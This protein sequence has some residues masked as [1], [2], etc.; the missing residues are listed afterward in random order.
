V[1]RAARS[2]AARIN[3][4]RVL[5]RSGAGSFICKACGTHVYEWDGQYDYTDWELLLPKS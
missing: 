2:S 5:H 1:Q 3:C 4:S